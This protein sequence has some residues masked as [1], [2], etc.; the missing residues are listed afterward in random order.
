MRFRNL[1]LNL[2]VVLDV[3][4]QERNV[5]RAGDRLCLTQSAVS[6]SLRCLR[7]YFG[8]PLLI[9]DG[10]R[11]FLS[12]KA[13]L[14]APEIAEILRRI[15]GTLTDRPSEFDPERSVREFVVSA[16]EYIGSMV[17]PPLMRA[18]STESPGVRLTMLTHQPEEMVPLGNGDIH[19]SL[20]QAGSVEPDV[21]QEKLFEDEFVWVMPKEHALANEPVTLERFVGAK[22]A[23]YLG[24]RI[25]ANGPVDTAL[26][27]HGLVREIHFSA[28][29]LH[30][31]GHVLEGGGLTAVLPRLHSAQL[32]NCIA[33]P[34]PFTLPHLRPTMYWHVSSDAGPGEIWLRSMVRRAA[35][36]LRPPPAAAEAL[37][38]EFVD[39][40]VV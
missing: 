24:S 39:D 11:M 10:N 34:L 26:L 25:F 5:T 3:L 16:T 31:L 18:L 30:T 20:G 23:V 28:D 33:R 21:L 32:A 2:L 37:S 22:H 19:L 35:R 12:A 15:S 6:H 13:E 17:L 36:A 27:E 38:D 14:L 8:D 7:T 9:R 4:L 1:D 40:G 29:S